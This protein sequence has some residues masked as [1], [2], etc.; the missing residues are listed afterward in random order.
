MWWEL[1]R[2]PIELARERVNQCTMRTYLRT[3]K[4]IV[5]FNPFVKINEHEHV[6]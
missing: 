4:L 2:E 1:N 3:P 5:L 6:H